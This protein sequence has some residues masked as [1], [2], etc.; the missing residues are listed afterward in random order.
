VDLCPECAAHQLD[1]SPG[2]W[3]AVTAGAAPGRVPIGWRFVPC[4]DPGP[5]RFVAAA[6]VN[7]WWIGVVVSDHRY[8]LA[9]VA[10]LPSGAS[11]WVP[12]AR[13][14]YNTWIASAGGAGF[15]PPL[16]FRATD[17]FGQV[18]TSGPMAIIADGA[19]ATA[20]Q[21]HACEP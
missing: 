6:G 14:A 2:A 5:V 15:A 13:T 16:A 4:P 3:S 19:T 18:T 11:A 17:V 10:L 12:L 20:P 21:L 7:P 8:P 1:L 9:A